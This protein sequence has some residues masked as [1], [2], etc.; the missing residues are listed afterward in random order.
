MLLMSKTYTLN[1][2]VPSTGNVALTIFFIEDIQSWALSVFFNFSI[3]KNDF[4]HFYQVNL[5]LSGLFK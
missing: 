2:P 1:G 5:T 4:M 3:M